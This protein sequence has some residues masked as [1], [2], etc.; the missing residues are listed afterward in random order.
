MSLSDRKVK[1]LNQMHDLSP[2]QLNKNTKLIDTALNFLCKAGYLRVDTPVIEDS[3]LFIRKG[4]G[5]LM[6]LVCTFLDSRGH[7][8]SLRPEFTSS[9]IRLYLEQSNNTSTKTKWSYAGP[10]FRYRSHGQM[11]LEQFTQVGGEIIGKSGPETD[12]ELIA[13][14]YKGLIELGIDNPVMKIGHAKSLMYFFNTFEISESAKQFIKSNLWSIRSG[15]TNREELMQRAIDSGLTDENNSISSNIDSS[16]TLVELESLSK[17]QVNNPL[18][19]RTPSEIIS[20]LE[21]K[22]MA[23]NDMAEFSSALDFASKLLAI[24]GDAI[25]SLKQVK[26]LIRFEGL[27]EETMQPL[28][29]LLDELKKVDVPIKN[30]GLDFGMARGIAYYTGMIFELN[31]PNSEFLLGGGGRYDQLVANLGGVETDALGFAYNIDAIN[32]SSR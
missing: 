12:A 20:L 4:G 17:D 15:K 11:L 3:G 19:R 13:T 31:C 25:N 10:V 23:K 32:K 16:Q 2:D 14:A 8:V 7:R 28:E 5:E 18:G 30:M 27:A 6:G 9:I 29:V 22:R 24:N 26:E 21:E 1:R